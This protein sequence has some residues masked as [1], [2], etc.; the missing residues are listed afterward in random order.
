MGWTCPI[1]SKSSTEN[2]SPEHSSHHRSHL[3]IY[4]LDYPRVRLRLHQPWHGLRADKSSL[5]H[6]NMISYTALPR[7][8][9][10]IQCKSYNFSYE[11]I[12][13]RSS[14]NM[15]SSRKIPTQRLLT[16]RIPIL[17]E[18][19]KIRPI[20]H[21]GLLPKQPKSVISG[22]FHLARSR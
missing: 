22:P 19:L 21:R 3:D 12:R 4:S 11:T 13:C 6:R 2:Y 8:L 7:L 14:G 20:S 9:Y 10:N 5:R 18:S 15:S 16:D 17:I 1:F